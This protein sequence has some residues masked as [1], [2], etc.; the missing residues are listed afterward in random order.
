M[1]EL[2]QSRTEQATSYKLEQARKKG[3][4]PRG[5]E[6]SGFCVVAAFTAYLWIFGGGL[7]EDLLRVNR[8]ALAEA[9]TLVF[10]A[11]E[12][13][14]WLMRTVS[15]AVH[16][17]APLMVVLMVVAALSIVLQ[18][19]IGFSPAALKPDFTRLNPLNGFKR[20]FSLQA[21]F[22]TVKAVL[23]LVVF[24]LLAYWVIKDAALGAA[25]FNADPRGSA[26]MM[27]QAALRLMFWLLG[28]A[29]V[30]AVIDLMFVRWQF[31]K[32]MMMSRRELR[33][34]MRQREGDQRIKQRRKQLAQEILK[35]AR[36][37]RQLRGAD[38]LIT[39]PTH[40]AVAL[41]YDRAS[42][43][44]PTVVSKAAGEFALRL[45]RLA[46]IYG[47]PII[48]S[49]RLARGLFFKVP[50]DQEIPEAF[51]TDTAAIYLREHAR[52]QAASGAT[53]PA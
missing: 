39:N 21:L 5:V 32:K 18:I 43:A 46:F 25:M 19:G 22:E 42:M 35:R 4:V 7:V 45:K 26:T 37:M 44:A 3:M 24:G 13:W 17:L 9:P 53:A 14:I 31:G 1:A 34:E 29:L 16:A 11:Q 28:G 52:R 12:L 48:E 41:K 15:G 49:P 47:V 20:I 23:K 8:R 51:Y 36:S 10:G 2:E 27:G 50:M 33:E 6:F 38:F 30:F 40:Y